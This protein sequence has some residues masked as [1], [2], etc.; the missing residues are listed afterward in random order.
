MKRAAIFLIITLLC[1]H[2]LADFKATLIGWDATLTADGTPYSDAKLADFVATGHVYHTAVAAAVKMRIYDWTGD[3]AYADRGVVFMQAIVDNAGN[4]S[5][6]FFLPYPFTDAYVRI[7]DAGFMTAQLDADLTAF[8]EANFTTVDINPHA[9]DIHNQHFAR[10]A[11]LAYAAAVW[12]GSSKALQWLT[13]SNAYMDKVIANGDAVENATNYDYICSFYMWHMADKLGRVAEMEAMKGYF[14]RCADYI[15]PSGKTPDFGDSGQ[16]Q[17]DPDWPMS[18]FTAGFRIAPMYRAAAHFDDPKMQWAA[19]NIYNIITQREQL[20][21]FGYTGEVPLYAMTYMEDWK[22]EI[23]YQTPEFESTVTTKR[24]K[25]YLNDPVSD[26]EDKLILCQSKDAGDPYLMMDLFTPHGSHTHINQ[27]VSVNYYEYDGVPL[28]TTN[29][30]HGWGPESSNLCLIRDVSDSF[31]YP[32]PAYSAA[33]WQ[34]L[35]IPLDNIRTFGPHG[36][37]TYDTI[38][39]RMN[40]TSGTLL[41]GRFDNLRLS[42]PAGEVLIDDFESLDGWTISGLKSLINYD[43]TQGSNSMQIGYTE[44]GTWFNTKSYGPTTVDLEQYTNVKLDWKYSNNLT[45]VRPLIFRFESNEST[46]MSDFHANFLQMFSRR[47][48]TIAADCGQVS[49]GS[50]KCDEYFTY[51]TKFARRMLMTADGVLI[52]RDDMLAGN[53][54]A[55]RNAGPLWNLASTGEPQSGPQWVDSNGGNKELLVFMDSVNG[56]DEY[57]YQ[58]IDISYARQGQRAAFTRKVLQ[59]GESERFMSVL[60]PHSPLADVNTIVSSISVLQDAAGFEGSSSVT[61]NVAGEAKT[62]VIDVLYED[63]T[64]SIVVYG[65]T[66]GMMAINAC[67]KLPQFRT[68]GPLTYDAAELQINY[69]ASS[70][71]ELKSFEAKTAKKIVYNGVTLLNCETAVTANINYGAGETTGVIDADDEIIVNIY[72]P[73]ECVNLENTEGEPII[74]SYDPD[75][76]SYEFVTGLNDCQSIIQSGLKLDADISGPEGEPDCMVDIWDLAEF[77]KQWLRS[78][79]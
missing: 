56:A 11:G 35:E 62:Y 69:D 58:T 33:Q 52:V 64:T 18:C 73:V 25:T 14:S 3:D 40:N 2:T 44:D 19:D 50:V 77:T 79:I 70:G 61:L 13:Y 20:P 10:A 60:V 30:Y 31:P 28:L 42:G 66:A 27:H 41:A 54:A 22:T 32:V 75:T 72:S 74:G 34:T 48:K 16:V 24:Y 68:A 8:A 46:C 26:Y 71:D 59:A 38:N 63:D 39:L 15:A 78:V 23:A 67:D 29:G 17:Y 45:E 36:Q 53:E 65:D 21:D 9:D 1:V 76:M 49:Y 47:N 37:I 7:K 43:K 57:G 4:I 55:G 6:S 5:D 51:D 12:P